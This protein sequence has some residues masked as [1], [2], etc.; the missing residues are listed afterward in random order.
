MSEEQ[1]GYLVWGILAGIV[2]FPEVLAAVGREFVPGRGSP[3][4]WSTCRPEG[5]S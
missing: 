3:G 1:W 2:A 5:R 4:R